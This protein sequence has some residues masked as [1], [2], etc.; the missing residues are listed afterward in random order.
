MPHCENEKGIVR[1][2]AS[3]VVFKKLNKIPVSSDLK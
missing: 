2:P 3:I 1:N